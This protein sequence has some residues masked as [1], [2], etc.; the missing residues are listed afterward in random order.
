MSVEN[1]ETFKMQTISPFIAE[2]HVIPHGKE[3]K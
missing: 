1:S 3:L 2:G